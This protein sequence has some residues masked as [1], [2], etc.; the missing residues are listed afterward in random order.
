MAVLWFTPNNAVSEASALVKALSE[1]LD[2]QP[3]QPVRP[4]KVEFVEYDDGSL[5]A[6]S[7][8]PLMELV[9]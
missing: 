6:I 3:M 2:Q 9:K 5:S 4:L 8:A 1:W 7:T